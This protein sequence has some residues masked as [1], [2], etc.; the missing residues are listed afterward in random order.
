MD[1]MIG[2]SSK[3]SIHN[4]LLL[5]KQILKPIWTYGIPLWGCSADSNIKIIQSFQNKVTRDIV[6]APW[7]CRDSDLHRDLKIN[8]VKKEIIIAANKHK[9][10][11]DIHQNYQAAKL[12]STKGKIRRL[13][14][15]KPT[16]LM[17]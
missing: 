11:L 4:K 1:W 10:R 5:Y 9:Q 13:K 14:K 17:D 6:K 3:L 15:V 7:Y 2:K 8:N 12:L 16:D